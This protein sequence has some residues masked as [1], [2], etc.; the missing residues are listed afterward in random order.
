MVNNMCKDAKIDGHFTNHSLRASGATELF[1]HNIPERVIQ[2]FTGHRSVKALRQYEKAAL[3]QKQAACNILTGTAPTQE[4]SS[5]VHKVHSE[6]RTHVLQG[7]FTE[8][9]SSV[10]ELP[11]PP[12]VFNPVINNHGGLPPPVF[13][14]VINNHGGTVNFTVNICPSRNTTVGSTLQPT[15]KL[16]D[17][18]ELFDGVDID[19]FFN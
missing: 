13:N 17:F 12:P 14:P 7:Q 4:F 15:T 3:E 5:A 9:A 16:C 10:A 6:S 1:Q 19:S 11:I 8:N 2:E 18:D